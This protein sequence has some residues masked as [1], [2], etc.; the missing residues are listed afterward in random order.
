MVQCCT[1]MRSR[2]NAAVKCVTSSV[3]N[4]NL[5][6]CFSMNLQCDLALSPD[7]PIMVTFFFSNSSI[8]A[9][10]PFASVVHPGVASFG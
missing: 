3:A 7:T 6:P 8:E 9:E 1:L 2:E 4:L 10:N 5:S